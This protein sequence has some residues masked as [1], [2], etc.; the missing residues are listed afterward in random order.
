MGSIMG[1]SRQRPLR[2]RG[3]P[4]GPAVE[5][6][7]SAAARGD[8][9]VAL[10][11]ALRGVCRPRGLGGGPGRARDREPV[12]LSE[13]PC[14]PDR[15]APSPEP[16]PGWVTRHPSPDLIVVLASMVVLCVGSKGQV[17]AT[18]A[19]RY[20][21]PQAVPAG[22]REPQAASWG[23]GRRLRPHTDLGFPGLE[24]QHE[25]F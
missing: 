6:A 12:S 16:V 9:W 4:L 14:P 18:S 17:F 8:G 22:L 23:R 25:P 13:G 10:D 7:A 21:G 24:A 15:E 20:S 19:I 11:T 3:D 1:A 2:P 5:E